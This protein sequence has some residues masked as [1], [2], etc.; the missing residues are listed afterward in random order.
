MNPRG[1]SE[2]LGEQLGKR[3]T[4]RF[5]ILSKEEEQ[6]IITNILK[7]WNALKTES[8]GSPNISDPPVAAYDNDMV[9]IN[10]KGRRGMY[11]FVYLVLWW[12]TLLESGLD[13][14]EWDTFTFDVTACCSAML[15]ERNYQ[16]ALEVN[17]GG[18]MH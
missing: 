8:G 1:R 12:G 9:R 11:Q 3:L 2:V 15:K 18:L 5:P 17:G 6:T 16:V 4:T 7:S 14:K 10:K 13:T